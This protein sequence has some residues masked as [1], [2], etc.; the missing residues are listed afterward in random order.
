[1][2]E[3]TTIETRR[4]AVTATYHGVDVT[5]D[6]TW[7]EDAASEE[8]Q[9]W[10]KAQQQRTSSYLAGVPGYADIRREGGGDHRRCLDV[11]RRAHAGRL[12]R[13]SR[14]STSRP[15]SSRS[16]SRSMTSGTHPPSASSSTRTRSTRAAR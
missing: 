5:D 8:T 16:S 3:L 11:V 15:S 4:H 12:S 7:L 6:Y 10:T 2:D 13:T 1:M 9:L 14:S